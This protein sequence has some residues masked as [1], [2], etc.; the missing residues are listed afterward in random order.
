MQKLLPIL[1][2]YVPI[3]LFTCKAHFKYVTHLLSA[4]FQFDHSQFIVNRVDLILK[5]SP[6][7]FVVIYLLSDGYLENVPAAEN[8]VRKLVMKEFSDESEK[9]AGH[10]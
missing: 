10:L 1:K 3:L 7:F 2:L 8:N 4:D 5:N 9:Y 6:L